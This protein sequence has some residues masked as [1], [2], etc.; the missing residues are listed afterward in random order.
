MS[1]SVAAILQH[2]KPTTPEVIEDREI[3]RAG[4]IKADRS[5]SAALFSA[6]I[7][8]DWRLLPGVVQLDWAI[9][10]GKQHFYARRGLREHDSDQVPQANSA[11]I[12]A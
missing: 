5:G 3:R 6:V 12:I 2:L 8:P 7:F 10:Y 4:E 1:S 11:R 9:Q